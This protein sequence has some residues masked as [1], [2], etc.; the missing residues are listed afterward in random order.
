MKPFNLEEAIELRKPVV[1]RDG[2]TVIL[3]GHN[4]RAHES[5]RILGWVGNNFFWY[6]REDG[7]NYFSKDVT[8]PLDLF[9]E[10]TEKF[11]GFFTYV[12]DG[13]IKMETTGCPFDTE[14]K[15][16]QCLDRISFLKDI[17]NRQVIKINV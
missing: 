10:S 15:A 7:C 6:W 11:V 12:K 8:S 5:C 14:E 9:M 2:R 13:E 4:P 17:Q 1:T 3:A 16:N